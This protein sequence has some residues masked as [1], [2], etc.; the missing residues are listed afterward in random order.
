MKNANRPTSEAQLAD[1]VANAA[2]H[3]E[4]LEVC[5]L[6]SRRKLGRPVQAASTVSTAAMTGI[7]LYEPTEFVMAALAGTPLATIENELDRNNQQLAFEPIDTGPMLGRPA[8]EAS[9]GSVFATNLSGPRR[10]LAGAARDHILGLRGVSGRGEIFKNGGRVMKNVTGYDLCR[11]LSG[12]WG[13]LAVMTELTTKVLPKAAQTHT[14][15]VAGLPDEIAVEVLCASMGTPFE[16]SGT[17]HLDEALAGRMSD[18]EISRSEAPVTAIRI[19]NFPDSIAYRSG[20]L[21]KMLQPFGDVIELDNERSLAFWKE[22]REL[23]FLTGSNDPVWRI[24]TA[25]QKGPR[26]VEAIRGYTECKVAY[27]W[28]GGLLWLEVPATADASSADIRRVMATL[29]GHVTL[30]RAEPDVRNSVEVFQPLE[31][32]LMAISQNLK[33]SFDPAGVLNPGRMYEQF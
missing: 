2:N 26:A 12:S 9:I 8:G 16:V 7:T 20:E 11:G 13:T 19:E 25:P 1:I 23:R 29:G 5:G 15:M 17:I 33:R 27:D 24:S 21:R 6:G 30:M 3:K 32:G 22:L 14:L 31:A 18:P 28:S 10:V 4:P